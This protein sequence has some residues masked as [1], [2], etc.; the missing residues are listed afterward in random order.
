MKKNQPQVKVKWAQLASPRGE[1]REGFWVLVNGQP[2]GNVPFA[3]RQEARRA[4][5]QL[6]TG[7]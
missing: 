5:R 1:V 2:V 7:D 3:T 4:R 6:P